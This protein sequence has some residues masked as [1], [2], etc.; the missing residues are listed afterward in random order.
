MPEGGREGIGREGSGREG[1]GREN[2]KVTKREGKD[3]VHHL[4]NLRE[5]DIQ[6]PI[7]Y[8]MLTWL[9]SRASRN[10]PHSFQIHLWKYPPVSSSSSPV[11]DHAAS[12]TLI[13]AIGSTTLTA[14]PTG[15]SSLLLSHPQ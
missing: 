12:S 8:S 15:L 7:K 13:T 2:G 6:W 5:L 4:T 9:K 11:D 10:T 14:C 3:N 1:R